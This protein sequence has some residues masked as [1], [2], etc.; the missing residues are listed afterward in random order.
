MIH[1]N[2]NIFGARTNITQFPCRTVRRRGGV[3]PSLR[4][5]TDIIPVPTPESCAP[6]PDSSSQRSSTMSKERS[7]YLGTSSPWSYSMFSSRTIICQLLTL[8]SIYIVLYY[9]GLLEG[10]LFSDAS[11][12]MT[13]PIPIMSSEIDNRTDRFTPK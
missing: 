8:T 9:T 10:G 4:L 12:F 2:I 11:A 7:N 13:S 5:G 1:S 3:L 6:L